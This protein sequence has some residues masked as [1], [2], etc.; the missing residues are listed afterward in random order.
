MRSETSEP[1]AG[2]Q[3]NREACFGLS[4]FRVKL[5]CCSDFG[6]CHPAR[7]VA[8]LL[9]DVVAPGAGRESLE[10]AAQIDGRL[11]LEPR[12]ARLAVE[13]AVTGPTGAIPRIGAPLATMRGGPS[14]VMRRS[15]GRGK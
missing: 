11:S 9:A 2:E 3:P 12:R 5:A 4:T 7:D 10:L 14:L 6:R 1:P 15:G 8:H 13:F